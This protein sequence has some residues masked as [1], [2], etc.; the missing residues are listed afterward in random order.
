MFKD[1]KKLNKKEQTHFKYAT[2]GVMTLWAFKENRV[3]QSKLQEIDN[4]VGLTRD[5]CIDCKRIA[6][7]LGLENW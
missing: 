2:N 5:V 7:K 3:N 1:F 6:V 4:Q